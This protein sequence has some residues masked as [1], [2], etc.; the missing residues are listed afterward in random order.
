MYLGLADAVSHR[1]LIFILA[2]ACAFFA[3]DRSY[4][5]ARL[6][7]GIGDSLMIP[8]FWLISALYQQRRRVAAWRWVPQRHFIACG[9]IVCGYLLDHVGWRIAFYSLGLLALLILLCSSSSRHQ[10]TNAPLSFD[11]RAFC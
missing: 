2:E 3:I 6:T 10:K 11:T 9:P 5:G 7:A 1:R 4:W 8:P